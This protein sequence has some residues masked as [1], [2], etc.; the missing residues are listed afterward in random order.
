M[1]TF[2][3]VKLEESKTDL[4]SVNSGLRQ[5]DSISLVLF[6]L[7]LE[8]VVREIDIGLQEGVSLYE[9]SVALLAYVDDLFLV[10][11]SHY[12]LKTLFSRL[13]EK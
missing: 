4:I 6:N 11:E 12:D 8:R 2:V 3:K 7:V 1:E 9:F 5:G 13:E 10:N